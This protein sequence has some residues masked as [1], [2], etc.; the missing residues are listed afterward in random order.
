MRR[1]AST[2]RTILNLIGIKTAAFTAATTDLITSAGHGLKNHDLIVLTTSGT[3]PAG[4]TASVPYVVEQATTNTFKLKLKSD[5]THPDVTDTGSGVQTWTMHNIGWSINCRNWKDKLVALDSD[6]GGDAE[7][8]VKFQVSDQDTEPDFSAV[9]TVSNQWDYAKVM[10]LEDRSE[11]DGDTGFVFN[12]DDNH[13][14]LLVQDNT[15][16]WINVIISLWVAGEVTAK[17][18]MA[19]DS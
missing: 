7:M 5:N 11:I 19:N 6:G 13:V 15:A 10:N 9:Q 1:G 14:R 18:R 8:T 16:K 12:G 4:L 17:I 3:L 2:I